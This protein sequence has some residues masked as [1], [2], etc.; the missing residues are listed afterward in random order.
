MADSA[1]VP[2]DLSSLLTGD[3]PVEASADERARGHDR[4]GEP[5][6]PGEP[7]APEDER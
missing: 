7:G 2:D 4:P 6:E 5:G 1:E 3:A